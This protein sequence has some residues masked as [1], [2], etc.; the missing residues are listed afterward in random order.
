[1]RLTLHFALIQLVLLIIMLPIN[2]REGPKVQHHTAKEHIGG[3]DSCTF[4]DLVLDLAKTRGENR[5]DEGLA[6]GQPP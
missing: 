1:M 3:T 6:Y 4:L 2:H 5:G